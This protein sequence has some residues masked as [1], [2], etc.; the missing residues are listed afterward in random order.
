MQIELINIYK[1][2]IIQASGIIIVI[3]YVAESK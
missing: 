2:N 3:N 1:P